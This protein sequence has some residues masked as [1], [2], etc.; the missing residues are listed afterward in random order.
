[1]RQHI[2]KVS[3]QV[4]ELQTAVNIEGLQIVRTVCDVED[5]HWQI[6]RNFWQKKMPVELEMKNISFCSFDLYSVTDNI[7]YRYLLE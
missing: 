2:D 5:Q 3:D 7:V 4:E 1:M 6:F